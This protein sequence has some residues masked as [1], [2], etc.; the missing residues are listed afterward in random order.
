MAADYFIQ[1]LLEAYSALDPDDRKQKIR[2]L[3]SE[4]SENEKF[5]QEHFPE[6][7][8]EAF[9]SRPAAARTWESS[10]RSGLCAKPE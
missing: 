3:V 2:E 10:V 7:L 1:C 6:F 9:P 5:I 4:S 8:D